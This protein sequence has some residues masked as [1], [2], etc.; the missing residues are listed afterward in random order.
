MEWSLMDLCQ[1]V[2]LCFKIIIGVTEAEFKSVVLN[3]IPR[4]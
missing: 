3:F 2:V 1:N 4:N